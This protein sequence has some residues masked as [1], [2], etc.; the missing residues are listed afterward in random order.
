MFDIVYTFV[1]R[2]D[3]GG[4]VVD[5]A[6]TLVF[7]I[8]QRAFTNLNMGDAS[9]EAVV[10]FVLIMIVT[11]VQFKLQDKWVFYG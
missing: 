7:G 9:A 2:A 6:R 3:Q 1:G 11:F 4:P 5:A 10:L 8:Y